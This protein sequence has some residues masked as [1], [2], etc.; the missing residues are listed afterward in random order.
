MSEIYNLINYLGTGDKEAIIVLLVLM[1]LLCGFVIKYLLGTI[2]DLRSQVD[3]KDAQVQDMMVN[4]YEANKLII[5]TL[6]GIQ[7]ILIEI[8]TKITTNTGRKN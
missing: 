8:K 7:A 5:N 2:K 3:K 1:V 4:Y 6:N